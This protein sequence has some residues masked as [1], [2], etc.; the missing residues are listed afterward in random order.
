M[1]TTPTKT[2]PKTYIYLR[3]YYMYSRREG[4]EKWELCKWQPPDY[5]ADMQIDAFASKAE[6]K[7]EAEKR[8]AYNKQY[9][10][11]VKEFAVALQVEEVTEDYAR[12]MERHPYKA[13]ILG[14]RKKRVKFN[15]RL[16]T[17]L[18]EITPL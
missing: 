12:S 10:F 6:A 2:K 4:T 1:S 8:I 14:A 15:A 18:L 9:N 11:P 17:K 7:T 3:T 5:G 13:L 16:H